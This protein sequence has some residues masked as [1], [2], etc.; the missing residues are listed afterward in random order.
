MIGGT[1][2]G[3]FLPKTSEMVANKDE[4][5][6]H[7]FAY[8][9][10]TYTTTIIAMMCFP[11][12]LC[13]SEVI[14]AYVGPEYTY[15]SKWLIIWCLTVL[16]QMHTTPGNALVLA[17]GK[18]KIL[19]FVTATA[20]IISMLINIWLCKYYDAGSAIIGYFIYTLIII[21]LYYISFYKKLLKLSRWKLFKSFARPVLVAIVVFVVVYKIPISISIFNSLNE[22][23]A[24]ILVCIIKS[25]IWIIPYII[26]LNILKIID[27]KQIIKK[28]GNLR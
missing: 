27:F 13:S 15:L 21:G 1:F 8:K 2:S 16:I 11:F 12:I 7:I 23:L 20:C 18:T 26:L 4:K 6:M 9:W 25:A 19:V 10:T 24:Y 3:I 5:T 28:N 17:H 22:R 14:S